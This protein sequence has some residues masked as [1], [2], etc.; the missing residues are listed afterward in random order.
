MRK[1]LFV[2]IIAGAAATGPILA[3]TPIPGLE[4]FTLGS[5]PSPTPT[6]VPTVATPPAPAPMV[7]PPA[8]TPTPADT[9][10]PRPTPTQSDRA[11]RPRATNTA[12]SVTPTATATPSAL[13]SAA[14]PTPPPVVSA[15]PVAPAVATPE[16]AAAPTNWTMWM[17]LGALALVLLGGFSWWRSR[18]RRSDDGYDEAPLE[19]YV[20]ADEFTAAPASPSVAPV[21]PEPPAPP[22]PSP[23]PPSSGLPGGLITSSLKRSG[24]GG[25]VTSSLSPELRLA[26]TPLR[27]GVDTLRATLEYELQVG[28]AG[29]GLARAVAVEAWLISASHHT[30]EDLGTLFASP[31][32]EPLL[33][34][35]DLAPNGAIDLAGVVELPREMIATISAGD[36]RMFV[37]LLAVRAVFTDGR[38]ERQVLTR[39]FLVGIRRDGQDRLAPLP[40]D[41]GARM[42]EGL[43]SRPYGD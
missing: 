13:P 2:A 36:R 42:N 35:F 27:G 10:T 40:L 18:E 43:A 8:T 32:G 9:P 17:A 15:P 1:S 16:P 7:T 11:P 4:N 29:R 6:P 34:P 30:A 21:A 20:S 33:A 23:T 24:G 41:R 12:P 38:G 37:P 14:A 25:L 31:A 3:Q 28:N 39:A 19:L 26:L 22:S 5:Q